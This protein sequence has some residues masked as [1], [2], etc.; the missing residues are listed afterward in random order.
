MTSFEVS[1]GTMCGRVV[2][3]T[4]RGLIF[5]TYEGEMVC[6]GMNQRLQSNGDISSIANTVSFSID[7]MAT[8]KEDTNTIFNSI[9]DN[10]Q[11]GNSVCLNYWK[12]FIKFPW[13]GSTRTFVTQVNT[14]Q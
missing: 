3:L 7:A 4:K 6:D 9:M 13:Q 12:P 8:K 14:R 2:R 11:K 1:R 10:M 5:K